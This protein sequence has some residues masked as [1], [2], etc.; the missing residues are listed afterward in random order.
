MYHDAKKGKKNPVSE[1]VFFCVICEQL[2]AQFFSQR[3]QNTSKTK[4]Y[5]EAKKCVLILSLTKIN[6]PFIFSSLSLLKVEERELQLCAS[7]NVVW[8][9]FLCECRNVGVGLD[10][11]ILRARVPNTAVCTHSGEQILL[12][13]SW[14][15]YQWYLPL[16]PQFYLRPDL[17]EWN[18][19]QQSSVLLG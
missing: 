9:G 3:K 14:Q 13:V 5:A 7:N 1:P 17:K 10:K 16:P 2:A 19:N 15:W 6:S 8:C 4:T 18:R 11:C 12:D